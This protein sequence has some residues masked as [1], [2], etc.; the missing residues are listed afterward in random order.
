MLVIGNLPVARALASLGKVMNYDVVA[1][2]PDSDG[3]AQTNASHIVNSLDDI[4]YYI[5]PDTFAVVATHGS[6]DETAL[7]QVLK[8]RPHYIGLV[9]SHKRF[10][11]VL[12][13]LRGQGID[14]ADLERIKAP[15]GLDIQA[16]GGDEIALSILAEIVQFRRKAQE[17]ADWNTPEVEITAAP[18]AQETASGIAIDPVC[19]MEVDIATAKFTYDY[20][21]KT[22]Y[23]CA[24]GCKMVFRKNPQA[25]LNPAI[26]LD[27]VCSMEVEIAS[28]QYQSDYHGTTYYFCGAGCKAT[29]DQNPEAYATVMH[30]H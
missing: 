24:P 14:E 5:R 25:Y 18:T 22:Y 11:A 4:A 17:A 6:Y 7:E 8:A 10:Q 27:P 29:F 15:A 2:D 26:A 20:E 28:A 21:G 12:E 13:Y 23:F 19:L 1:V 16:Q 30:H 3:S 9:A